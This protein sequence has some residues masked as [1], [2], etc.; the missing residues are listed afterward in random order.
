MSIDDAAAFAFA[1]ESATATFAPISA[2]IGSAVNIPELLVEPFLIH[3]VHPDEGGDHVLEG[4][5]NRF[6]R[7]TDI[8]LEAIRYWRRSGLPTCQNRW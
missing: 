8:C 4:I 1:S 7:G 2:E 6:F 3:G 5:I